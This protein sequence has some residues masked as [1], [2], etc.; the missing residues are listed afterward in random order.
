MLNSCLAGKNDLAL[1][2]FAEDEALEVQS[3]YL[4]SEA[5]ILLEN[6]PHSDAQDILDVSAHAF[7]G[8]S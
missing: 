3:A 8:H 5:S 2:L 7:K 4:A 1:H 6:T